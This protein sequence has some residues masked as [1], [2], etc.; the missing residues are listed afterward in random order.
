VTDPNGSPDPTADGHHAAAGPGP[1]PAGPKPSSAAPRP[2]PATP[3]YKGEPLDAE[4]GPGLGCFWSQ[5]VV[6][7]VLV[8]LTPVGV[9]NAWP[10]WLT[11]GMLFATLVL[12]L[13]AGQTVIFLLRLVAADRRSRR[14]PLR[15][16]TPTVGQ[17]EDAAV[18]N[19]AAEEATRADTAAEAAPSN[20]AA[21]EAV[22]S[23][24]ASE[25]PA[26]GQPLHDPGETPSAG[27]RQ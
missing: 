11:T 23:S 10:Q 6:L 9:V 7:A 26:D 15:G 14:R 27:M 16:E 20:T 13:L 1:T 2:S 18:T 5:V 12:L 21:E 19:T 25:A 24:P 3:L 4:R 17:L 22:L 8:V